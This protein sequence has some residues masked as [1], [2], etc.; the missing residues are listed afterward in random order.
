M[1]SDP[2]FLNNDWVSKSVEE[3]YLGTSDGSNLMDKL[4]V[5][6]IVIEVNLNNLFEKYNDEMIAVVAMSESKDGRQLDWVGRPEITNFTMIPGSKS[7][8][9][10]DMYNEEKPFSNKLKYEH[11]IKSVFRVIFL[12]I[13]TLRTQL[14]IGTKDQLL[15]LLIFY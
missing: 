3:G 2:F 8:E 10:R 7:K 11:L 1:R 4:N 5:L 13:T 12:I 14:Q 6:S 9:L 15:S